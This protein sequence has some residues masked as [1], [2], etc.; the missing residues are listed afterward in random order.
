MAG[1]RVFM[2]HHEPTLS[3]GNMAQKKYSFA[4]PAVRQS[5]Q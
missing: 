3:A 5:S 2:H 1:R 4:A